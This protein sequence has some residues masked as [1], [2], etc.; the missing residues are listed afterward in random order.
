MSFADKKLLESEGV[1]FAIIVNPA[2]AEKIFAASGHTFAEMLKLAD[3][4]QPLPTFPSK[5]RLSSQRQA[6]AIRKVESQNVVAVRPGSDP[7]LKR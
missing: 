7:K 2:N 1:Q 4:D 3:A 6:G 5:Y